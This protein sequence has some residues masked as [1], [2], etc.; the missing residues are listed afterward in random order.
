MGS[1]ICGKIFRDNDGKV[2]LQ[3]EK[4]LINKDFP[5]KRQ[6]RKWKDDLG[7]AHEVVVAMREE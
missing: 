1:S 4:V 6:N 3:I 2:L 7:L 5:Y